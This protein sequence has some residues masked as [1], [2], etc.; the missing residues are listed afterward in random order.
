LIK[1]SGGKRAAGISKWNY[2][3]AR[4]AGAFAHKTAFPHC[5]SVCIQKQLDDYHKSKGLDDNTP[6]RTDTTTRSSG[7]LK[8][9]DRK[10][11]EAE[12]NRLRG[13]NTVAV[14]TL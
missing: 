9:E 13:V 2:G 6:V 7:R 14:P 11:L 10:A 5:N 1:G 3:Q 8:P 4:D 12:I